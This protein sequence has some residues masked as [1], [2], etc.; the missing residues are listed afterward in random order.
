MMNLFAKKCVD[1]PLLSDVEIAKNKFIQSKQ[2]FLLVYL[3]WAKHLLS[4]IHFKAL[5]KAASAS[6]GLFILSKYIH[7]KGNRKRRHGEEA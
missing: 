3:N 5:N 2:G 6:P 1:V 4:T 7:T